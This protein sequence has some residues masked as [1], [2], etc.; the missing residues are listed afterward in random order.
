MAFKSLSQNKL[1][2]QKTQNFIDSRENG[3]EISHEA[4]RNILVHENIMNDEN[5]KLE[6]VRE[7]D[8]EHSS[9]ESENNETDNNTSSRK[10]LRTDNRT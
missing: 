2:D 3:S 8:E 10:S 7:F 4:T 9:N 6:E 1:K 5:G